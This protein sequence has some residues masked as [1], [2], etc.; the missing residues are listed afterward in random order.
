MSKKSLS[1]IVPCLNEEQNLRGTYDNVV[2]ATKQTMEEYEILIFNDGSTDR[3]GSIADKIAAHDPHVTVVHNHPNKGFGYNFSAG[4]AIAKMNYVVVIP[5]DNEISRDSMTRIFGLAGKADIVIPFTVNTELRT[6]GRRLVSR[7][8]TVLANA[9]FQCELQYYNG[10]ALHRLDLVRHL[11]P[12]TA[13]FGFQSV[14]LI[15]LIRRGY[16][17]CEV[18][19]YLQRKRIYQSSAVRVRNIISVVAT[20]VRL[21]IDVRRDPALRRFQGPNRKNPHVD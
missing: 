16:S 20:L 2:A 9:L 14:L 8:Y 13:G 3:T 6:W 1:V 7:L 19:M 18:D 4:V 5:G 11:D 17:F 21:A 15:K 12:K 10:P